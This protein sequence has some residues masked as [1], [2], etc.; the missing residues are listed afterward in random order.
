[1]KLD[2]TTPKLSNNKL[3]QS[4]LPG[5]YSDL[6]ASELQWQSLH[7]AAAAACRGLTKTGQISFQI[8][9]SFSQKYY[10]K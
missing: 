9:D 6:T 3:S 2:K 7:M 10:M 1:M 5:G 8:D 4:V